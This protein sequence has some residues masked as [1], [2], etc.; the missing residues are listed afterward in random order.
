MQCGY[1]IVYGSRSTQKSGLIPQ[2]ATILSHAEAAETSDIIIVAV[3]RVHYN[4]LESLREILDEKVLVDVSNN[5]KINQYA[6]SNAEYLAQLLPGSKV[7]K[8][9]NT[10]S[11][12][13][14]QSGGLDASRQSYLGYLTLILCT[15][16]T[17][18]YVLYKTGK[19]WRDRREIHGQKRRHLQF[20]REETFSNPFLSRQ[21]F[22]PDFLRFGAAL[23]GHGEVAGGF[24]RVAN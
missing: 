24:R 12:W 5:L 2:G 3:Q 17:L 23:R 7:V 4:F 11:A 19:E 10:V 9:F 18:G 14:L 1:S 16:H 21:W 8:A 13:A 20:P 15:A 22:D 6:E